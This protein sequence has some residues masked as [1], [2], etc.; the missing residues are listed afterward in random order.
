MAGDERMVHAA[1]GTAVESCWMCG[2]RL[3]VSR[4]V[5]DGGSACA[6]VRWY[7]QDMRGCVERWTTVRSRLGDA[8]PGFP[9][10]PQPRGWQPGG[11]NH[12]PA[13]LSA[14]PPARAG[15]VPWGSA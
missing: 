14:P 1:A 8:R 10:S 15:Q 12:G 7:C 11:R 2:I 4:L 3:P 6:D 5:A 9:E 13:P